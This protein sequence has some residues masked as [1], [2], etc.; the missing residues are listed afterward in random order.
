MDVL[1][2]ILAAEEGR[3]VCETNRSTKE[4]SKINIIGQKINNL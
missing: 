1:D 3:V 2:H 4:L